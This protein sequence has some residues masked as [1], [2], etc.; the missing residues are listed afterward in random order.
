MEIVGEDSDKKK[1]EQKKENDSP[2]EFKSQLNEIRYWK[3]ADFWRKMVAIEFP[4][5][6]NGSFEKY[7]CLKQEFIENQRN[8]EIR[9]RI[10]NERR[11]QLELR[12]L[13]L[14]RQHRE[15][16]MVDS[17]RVAL[18][19]YI[20]AVTLILAMVQLFFLLLRWDWVRFFAI[21]FFKVKPFCTKKMAL[22]EIKT[23]AAIDMVFCNNSGLGFK[24]LWTTYCWQIFLILCSD[25]RNDYIH[26]ASKSKN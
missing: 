11:Q 14:H 15:K 21:Q 19:A 2:S 22:A 10:E 4:E 23:S 18:F 16:K 7:I 9:E 26:G 8:N 12:Q 6:K 13:V 3:R 5:E 25:D 20:S 1:Y 24:M 17:V